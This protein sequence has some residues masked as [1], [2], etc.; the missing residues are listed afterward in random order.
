MAFS[1]GLIAG[2]IAMLCWGI[3]DF[4]Q[5][6]VIR[7]LGSLKTMFFGNLLGIIITLIITFFYMKSGGIIYIT[8]V[9]LGLIVLLGLIDVIAV[10]SFFRSFELGEVSIVTP[11][12]AAF[13]F[14]TVILAILFLGEKPSL[15]K[16]ASII[17]IVLGII[18]ASIDLRK[19]KNF[20]T[21][22][23]VKESLIALFL[24]GIYFFV[25]GFISRNL[26]PVYLSKY[27]LPLAEGMK[28]VAINIFIFTGIFNSLF[29]LLYPV[30][31]KEIIK[32][33]DLKIKYMLL[34]FIINTF[35]Y[36]LAWAAVN[37]GLV[38][39]MISLVTPVSSLYP[40]ITVILAVIFLK[41]KMVLNQKIGV[42]TILFGV[43]LISL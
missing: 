11:I 18:L 33:A 43:F 14:V 19:L 42:L 31:K 36:T 6:L 5:A 22:K 8:P 39:E 20:K 2:L 1:I 26:L 28:I 12:S 35:L 9:T 15:L 24:W 37:Y 32:P 17:L 40:A 41:E 25:L 3:A 4:L 21:A 27:N 7:R 29:M 16:I 38:Q 10:Y 30:L 23:G 34:L 13:S